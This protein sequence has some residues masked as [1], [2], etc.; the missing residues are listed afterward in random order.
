MAHARAPWFHAEKRGWVICSGTPEAAV[1]IATAI[2]E[3]DARL[4]AA[5]PDLLEACKKQH[6][7]IDMLLALLVIR[8][9]KDD[10]LQQLKTGVPWD[11]IKAGRAAIA[12][13][14]GL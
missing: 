12:K 7:A 4:I 8:S 10:T 1:L 6:G 14:E 11:A 2:T 9:P 13:A 5:A 3:D